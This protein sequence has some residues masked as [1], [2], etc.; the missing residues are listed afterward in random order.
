LEAA[1]RKADESDQWFRDAVVAHDAET[2]S[3]TD[4]LGQANDR[5]E[6]ERAERDTVQRELDRLRQRR[7][8][9][10][11]LKVAGL[12]RPVFRV[13]RHQ[14]QGPGSNQ[15]APEAGGGSDPTPVEQSKELPVS[16]ANEVPDPT[17]PPPVPENATFSSAVGYLLS[18]GVPREFQQAWSEGEAR[19]S[20]LRDGQDHPSVSVIMPTFNRASL[21]GDAIRSVLDQTYSEWELIVCDDGSTDDTKAV[22]DGFSDSRI[23]YIVVP[24]GGAAKARNAGLAA[25]QGHLVAYLDTDNLWHPR[26]L[27]TMASTLSSHAGHHAAYCRYIDVF[28]VDGR[29]QLRAFASLPFDYDALS[30]KNFIDLNGFVHRRILYTRLGGFDERLVRQQDWDLILRYTFVRDPIYVDR[31][32]M[33]YQRN[34][35]WGQITTTERDDKSSPVLIRSALTASYKHGS[36]RSVPVPLPDTAFVLSQACGRGTYFMNAIAESVFRR[37]NSKLVTFDFSGSEADSF[38]ITTD[39]DLPSLRFPGL[40]FPEWNPTMA[41]AAANLGSDVVVALD[42]RLPSL[43]SALLA[44]Y[45][46]GT[47]IIVVDLD[48]ADSGIPPNDMESL[49]DLDPGHPELLD[50]MSSLWTH[51]LR[52]LV[53]RIPFRISPF[54]GRED[55]PTSPEFLVRYPWNEREPDISTFDRAAIRRRLGMEFDERWL[56][57]E[58]PIEH[59]SGVFELAGLV[60]P[61]DT[62]YRL[63]AVVAGPSP[64]VAALRR[65]GGS[66]VQVVESPNAE[67]LATLQI[68]SDAVIIWT[69]PK[70]AARHLDAQRRL[71]SALAMQTPILANDVADFGRLAQQGY[72]TLTRFRDISDL[73]KALDQIFVDQLPGPDSVARGHRLFR[74]QFSKNSVRLAV[75]MALVEAASA[76]G[77]LT[78]AEEFADF[79]SAFQTKL[80]RNATT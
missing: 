10:L 47:S 40:R 59:D 75:E 76:A 49:A 25:A 37:S 57:Y 44:N 15:P 58:G 20:P 79:T 6:I 66:R 8:V 73:E 22:V 19:D 35:Q 54:E 67:D 70:D 14:G 36:P 41:Q 51:I 74:R 24:R 29:P 62:A 23:R 77:V 4:L 30:E 53:S 18:K 16:M 72:L 60:H 11:A 38:A 21:I 46:F 33:L 2:R 52:S 31:L 50:P 17:A 13:M 5:L 78:V 1:E 26:F 9:R 34:E 3:L 48:D 12:A 65:I 42:A 7:S 28:V 63:T 71:S 64:D 45:H 39:V 27:E 69:D 61:P 68:A 32:L 80:S 56:L 43:G 55:D